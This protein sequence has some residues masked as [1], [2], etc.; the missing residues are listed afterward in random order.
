MGCTVDVSLTEV[1]DIYET[2]DSKCAYCGQDAGSPDHLIPL[3]ERG[4]CVAANIVPC[5]QECKFKKH[6]HNIV[7]FYRNGGVNKEQ[8]SH[9]VGIAIGLKNGDVIKEHIRSLLPT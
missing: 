4:L 1:L 3:K 8:M 2:Y 6:T 9:I 5:C 7:W